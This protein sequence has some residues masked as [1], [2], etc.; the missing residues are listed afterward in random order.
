MYSISPSRFTSLLNLSVPMIN[1]SLGLLLYRFLIWGPLSTREADYPGTGVLWIVHMEAFYLAVLFVKGLFQAFM[2]SWFK[3]MVLCSL[4]LLC[5]HFDAN[6]LVCS[7]YLQ[8]H[9]SF[10]GRRAEDCE[11][12]V[13]DSENKRKAVFK[14]LEWQ[15][16]DAFLLVLVFQEEILFFTRR[17]WLRKNPVYSPY[18]CLLLLWGDC[19]LNEH[20]CFPVDE[21]FLNG[22]TIWI[23][24]VLGFNIYFMTIVNICYYY[25]RW[26]IDR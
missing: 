9:P 5:L 15:C 17:W 12:G 10:L 26:S 25:K 7:L 18:L 3:V 6:S 8:N 21:R 16:N 4:C 23:Y 22:S 1:Y 19:I 20:F 13:E 11:E 2:L 24:I 14:E